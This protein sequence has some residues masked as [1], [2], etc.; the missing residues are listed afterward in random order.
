MNRGSSEFLLAF[1][2]LAV[3]VVPLFMAIAWRLLRK[4]SGSTGLV[5]LSLGTMIPGLGFCMEYWLR[6]LV[7]KLLAAKVEIEPH[8]LVMFWPAGILVVFGPILLGISVWMSGE[9]ENVWRIRALILSCAAS[10][11]FSAVCVFLSF[12]M[13]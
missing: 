1:L 2:W 7:P 12:I 6:L 13:V 10:W 3:G 4:G 11:A 9:S 5:W 8:D